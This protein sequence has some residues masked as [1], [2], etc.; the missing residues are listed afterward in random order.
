MSEFDGVP[1]NPILHK[2]YQPVAFVD[3]LR[4]FGKL[5]QIF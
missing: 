5:R 3:S 2:H 1:Q 4:V